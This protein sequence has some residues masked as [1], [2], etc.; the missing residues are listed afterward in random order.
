MTHLVNDCNHWISY[1]LIE[2]FLNAGYKVEGLENKEKDDYLLMFFGRNSNFSITDDYKKK[3]YHAVIS[4]HQPVD[5]V[6]T[7][8]TYIVNPIDNQHKIDGIA[9]IQVPLLFGEWM[10]MNKQGMYVN[11][12]FISF[13]SEY[14][15]T[16]SIYIKDFTKVF[17]QWM[18]KGNNNQEMEIIS[19]ND[20]SERVKL[21]N[22]LYLRD[23]GPIEEQLNQVIEH[24]ATYRKIYNR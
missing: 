22:L 5:N 16:K 13:D 1:H 10:P 15:L 18:Q 19:K 21:E 12:K 8:K 24:Y 7:E 6:K 3:H 2:E 20:K 23:N 14:F 17:V 9:Y 4:L 11:K